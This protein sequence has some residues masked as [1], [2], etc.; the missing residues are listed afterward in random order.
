MREV[1]STWSYSDFHYWKKS[2][3]FADSRRNLYG[4]LRALIEIDVAYNCLTHIESVVLLA[5]K[6]KNE[7]ENA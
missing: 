2:A 7:V 4:A 1:N 3:F 6:S 5:T